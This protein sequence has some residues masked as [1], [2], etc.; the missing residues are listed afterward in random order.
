MPLVRFLA[1]YRT[2]F[3]RTQG[4]RP[5]SKSETLGSFLDQIREMTTIFL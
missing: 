2:T 1:T 3:P 4:T 5:I